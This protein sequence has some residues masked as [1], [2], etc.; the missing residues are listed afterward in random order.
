MQIINFTNLNGSTSKSK[1]LNS[2]QLNFN[3]KTNMTAIFDTVSFGMNSNSGE[4]LPKTKELLVKVLEKLNQKNQ[5]RS[6]GYANAV[7]NDK[8]VLKYYDNNCENLITT[9]SELFSQSPDGKIVTFKK[10]G[11]NGKSDEFL[12]EGLTPNKNKYNCTTINING[13]K[14]TAKSGEKPELGAIAQ[15]SKEIKIDSM[16]EIEQLNETIQGFLNSF[17]TKENTNF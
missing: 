12:I 16:Q 1:A 3:A 15:N 14:V 8:D 5:K 9:I 11:Q 10:V 7:K 4:I 2:K 6:Q 17:L 13:D